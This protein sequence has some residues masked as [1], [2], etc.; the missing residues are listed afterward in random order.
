M[1]TIM[2]ASLLL[3]V[4]AT[5]DGQV[6]PEAAS[7]TAAEQQA[8]A[9]IATPADY[10]IGPNDVLIITYWKEPEMTGDQVVRP[11][12]MITLPLLN[13]V[14]AMGLRPEQLRD[15]LLKISTMIKD[16]R[17]TVGVRT[18]NSRKVYISGAVGKP[19]PYDLL[20]PMRV[21]QLIALAG[22]VSEFADEKNISIIRIEGL[23]QEYFKYNNKEVREGKRLEQNIFL[24]PGDTVTVSE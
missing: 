15:N 19:G 7:P 1:G 10:V 12:G 22:G 20:V 14:P 6:R 4:V 9:G 8:A 11:D 5:L 18:I 3:S 2:A 21:N 17:I 23:K 13:D 16:P 24:K